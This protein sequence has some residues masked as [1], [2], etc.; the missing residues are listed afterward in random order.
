MVDF[1]WM[2]NLISASKFI[3]KFTQV[4]LPNA[5]SHDLHYC[6]QAEYFVHL[7]SSL[8][9]LSNIF[10]YCVELVPIDTLDR[11]FTI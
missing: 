4:T 11:Y 6:L 7:M 1:Q 2:F 8:G 5:L 10:R 9:A 3:S